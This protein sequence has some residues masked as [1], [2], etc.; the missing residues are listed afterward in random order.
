MKMR[1]VLALAAVGML[2]MCL[3]ARPVLQAQQA[4]PGSYGFQRTARAA[5]LRHALQELQVSEEQKMAG[6]AVL[7][8]HRAALR[9]LADGVVRERIALRN[10]YKAP[11][12]DEAAVRA[13]SARV[14]AIEADIAVQKAY[15][16]HDLRALAT[17]D[18]LKT[19]DRM[20]ADA[21]T[22]I[23]HAVDTIDDWIAN[24]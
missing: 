6:L 4:S 12:V 14:S 17:P 15:L 20:Q 8:N 24:S 9:P 16:I 1:S 19:L 10:L 2:A 7:R 13:Q 18:Q 3:L 21:E 5:V 23:E 22:R 11:A